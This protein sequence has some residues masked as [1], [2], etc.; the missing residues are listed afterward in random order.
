MVHETN[1]ISNDDAYVKSPM[2]QGIGTRLSA[3]KADA[4]KQERTLKRNAGLV[5]DIDI[6]VHES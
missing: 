6:R 3:R 5:K 4:D 2:G 1:I